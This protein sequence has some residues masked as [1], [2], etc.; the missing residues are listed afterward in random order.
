[1]YSEA[2]LFPSPSSLQLLLSSSSFF[3]VVFFF[4][5]L[6]APRISVAGNGHDNPLNIVLDSPVFSQNFGIF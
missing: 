5:S 6:L 1:M 2:D 3:F 4:L